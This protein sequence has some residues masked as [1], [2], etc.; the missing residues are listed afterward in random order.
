MSEP[1]G[2]RMDWPPTPPADPTF[3][4]RL[5]SE[6]ASGAIASRQLVARPRVRRARV[7]WFAAAAAAGLLLTWGV[8][9]DGTSW[10]VESDGAGVALDVNGRS[11][12]AVPAT[13]RAGDEVQLRTGSLD[14]VMPGV[15]RLQVAEGTKLRVP[16]LPRFAALRHGRARVL[17][18]EARLATEAGYRG[19]RLDFDL[20]T[21]SAQVTGT[22]MAVL[23]EGGQ[24]CVCVLEGVVKMR[25]ARGHVVRVDAGTRRSVGPEGS[26]AVVEPIRP[27]EA[28]KLEMLRDRLGR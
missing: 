19:R 18:G 7:A 10:R 23:I 11:A 1:R 9:A 20:P 6:F 16:A 17:A 21:A 13:L 27:M 28:M 4:E 25:D 14:L 24:S 22:V 26:E 3:R 12:E 5:R 8:L 15:A 2:A